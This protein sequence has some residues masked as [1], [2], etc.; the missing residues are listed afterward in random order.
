MQ[1]ILRWWQQSRS[2]ETRTRGRRC[3][4]FADLSDYAPSNIM[5]DRRVVRGPTYASIIM[6][7][8]VLPPKP[9]PHDTP[10]KTQTR[11]KP[12]SEERQVETPKLAEGRA[13]EAVQTEELREELTDNAAEGVYGAQ[14][15]FYI[16][17]PVTAGGKVGHAFVRAA[18][19]GRGHEYAGER[20]GL[21]R[22]R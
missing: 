11:M 7:A 16:D 10:K 22:L 14:T 2:S 5:Y 3:T 21:V 18:E 15:D 17:R 19:E 4:Q 12:E 1:L 20:R 13:H 9:R 6:P 8:T